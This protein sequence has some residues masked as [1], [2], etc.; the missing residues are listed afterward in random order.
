MTIPDAQIQASTWPT[1]RE[2]HAKLD[3]NLWVTNIRNTGKIVEREG[4][5][6]EGRGVGY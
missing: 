3:M 2:H 6:E 1:M 4:G 5:R